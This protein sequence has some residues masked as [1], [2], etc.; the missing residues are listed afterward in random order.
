MVASLGEKLSHIGQWKNTFISFLVTIILFV[1]GIALYFVSVR[2]ILIAW[3][4]N[5][6]RKFY[7]TPNLVDNNEIFDLLTRIPSFPEIERY[8]Q[9]KRNGA[10]LIEEETGGRRQQEIDT[11]M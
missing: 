5:K 9:V 11:S 3:G 6:F 8:R 1:A 7:M 10:S 2:Y 4:L